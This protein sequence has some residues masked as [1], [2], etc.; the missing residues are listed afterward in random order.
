MWPVRLCRRR[1]SAPTGS[2]TRWKCRAWLAGDPP[3]QAGERAAT[4]GE[5]IGAEA[6]IR[7]QQPERGLLPPIEFLPHLHGSPLEQLFGE[8][9]IK[10][11]LNQIETWCR[12]GLEMKVSVNISAN[13]LLQADFCSY[14][15]QALAR[16]ADIR[17]AL[18]ELEV[19][20]TAAIDDMQQAV[21]IL[22]CCRNLGVKFSLDDFGTGYSSLAYLRKLPVDTLKID[23]SFV[24]DMLTNPD[25]LS[26]VHGG[27]ELAAAFHRRGR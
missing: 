2:C 27:I 10:T 1:A 23:Q 5:V 18:L 8:W 19:L 16:H 11:A 4:R 20:E 13:H 24:R 6:L 7:W 14:L 22:Q 17:P 25:D 12:L 21:D 3:C 9:V 15:A 26:I